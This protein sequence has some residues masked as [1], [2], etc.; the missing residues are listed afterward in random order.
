MRAAA[1]RAW[2][3]S[4]VAGLDSR[5]LLDCDTGQVTSTLTGLPPGVLSDLQLLWPDLPWKGA[6]GAHGAFHQVLL[7]P[8]V[9]ALRVRTG[10]AHEEAI[11][12]E[13]SLAA[14]LSSARL[15]VPRLLREPVHA[16]GWS[17]M[18]VELV[19]GEGRE[20][21]TWEQD[22]SDLLELLDTLTAAGE[23]HPELADSLPPARAWCGGA[24]WPDLVDE[25]TRS[26]ATSRAAARHRISTVLESEARAGRA[27]VH[28]DFGLHNILWPASG[29]PTMIDTDHAAWADPAVDIAPLLAVYGREAMSVDIPGLMLDRAAAHRRVLSLQVAAAAELRGDAS[30]RD[31]AIENFARRIRSGDPQ[32]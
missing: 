32:W 8:P 3:S 4:A 10:I 21:R 29:G 30:L 12:R 17:A 22:G 18:A 28:G 15:P 2:H 24:R 5:V 20:P 1:G 11:D 6:R 19:Q 23:Q 27:P 31:H 7:L 9:A 14:A 25:L 26:D 13:H 16:A